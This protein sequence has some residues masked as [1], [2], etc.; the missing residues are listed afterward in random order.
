MRTLRWKFFTPEDAPHCPLLLTAEFA[1]LS[2]RWGMEVTC[3]I[4]GS[5]LFGYR[6][7]V[8]NRQKY[9]CKL[10]KHNRL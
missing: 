5:V 6:A 7:L 2:Y 8:S 10:L 9:F 4:L 1:A 3:F